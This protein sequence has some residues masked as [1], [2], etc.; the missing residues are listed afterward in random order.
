MSKTAVLDVIQ[1][2]RDRFNMR[3]LLNAAYAQDQQEKAA[4]FRIIAEVADE[5]STPELVRPAAGQGFHRPRPHHQHPVEV[6][7]A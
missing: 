4:L 2:Q 6:Q 7:P 3:E 1:A 5:N